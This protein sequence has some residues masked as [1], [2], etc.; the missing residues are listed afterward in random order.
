[1][2]GYTR[3]S[4]PDITNGADVTAP[5]LNAEF[6]QVETAFGTGG[7]SHDGTAGNAPKINLA[8]S[9][10]GFLPSTNGGIGGKNNVTATSNPTITDDTGAGYAVGSVWINTSTDRAFICLSNNS[11]AAVWHEFVAITGANTIVPTATNTVDIGTNA[12]RFKNLLLSGTATIATNAT[13]GGTLGVTGNTT[14][15]GTLGVTGTL[16]A[17]GNATVGGTLGVT[18]N[19]T[20]SNLTVSGTN[21]IA[22]AD[23]N[24][25]AMDATVIGNTTPAAATFTTLT[26]N[27]SLVAATADINGGNIDGTIIGATTAAAGTFTNLTSTGTSTHATVDINGG[28][29]D[30]TTIGAN[31]AAA[32]SFTTVSTSG[33]ATLASADING[34]TIDGTIIGDSTPATITGTTVTGTSLVG[35]LTGNV[36]GNLTGN[37]TGNVAG[38]L[39]GNVTAGS[40]TSIFNNVTVNGTLDVTGTTIANVTDPSSAQDAATKNYVDTEVAA[41]VSSAPGTL[42]T[43]N[44]LAAALNDDPNFSTT[45][46]NSIATKLPLAGGTMSGAIAMGT[47]KITGLG[48]PTANQ[49]AATKKYTT[50]TFLPLAGGTVTGAIDVGNNKITASYTPSTG[51]DLTTKT[52]VDGIVGSSTAA[53]TSATA[54]ANS[55]TASASSATNSANSA[56]AS[57]SSATS[58]AASLATFQNQYHGAQSSAPTQDPDGSSLDLG[59]LYFDTTTNTMK[60]YGSGGW[61]NAGSSVNGTSDRQSYT[62]TAGQTVFAATYDSGYV[63][64]YLNGVKLLA[65]TDF[66]ATNGTSVVLASGAAVNDI[67]DIVA[68]GTFTL[69][70]HYDKT[71]S[72][73]RYLQL[74]GGT[75]TGGLTGTTAT[76]TG[77]LTVDTNTLKVDSSNNRVGVGTTSPATALDVVGNATITVADNSTNLSLVST[78]ADASVGPVLDLYRNSAS[79]ADYDVTGRIIFSAENDADEKTEYTRIITY[80][81]DVSNGSEDAAIQYYL[82]KDGTS[83]QRL[84]HSPTETV[85]NQDSAD[86]DFRVE[87]N[88]NANMLFVDGGNDLIGIGTSSPSMTLDVDGSSGPNDIV[89]FSGPNSGGLTFRNATSNEFI[90]HTATS[91]ALIFG[92]GGNNERARITSSGAFLVGTAGSDPHNASSSSDIG[93]AIRSDGRVHAGATGQNALAVNRIDEGA[94]ITIKKAGAITGSIASFGGLIQFGQGNANLKFSN[95]SDVI[96]PANGSG[97]DNNNAIDLGTSSAAFKSLYLSGT[98]G[99]NSST[100]FTSMDG[101]LMFDN[102]Y[103]SSALGPNKVVL[104]A[105]GNWVGGLGVSSNFLDIYTGGGIRFNKSAS[106]TS[107]SAQMTLDASGNLLVGRTS[108][109]ATGNGHSI[110]GGDSAIFSRD[111]SG[112]TMQIGRNAS[113]G[114][115]VRFLSNG[116][117]MG[118]IGVSS[119]YIWVNSGNVGLAFYPPADSVYPVDSSG[120]NR[121]NATDL[122]TSTV[123][124]DDIYATNGT[125]QT[126]D[127]NEK[128]D[129][130]ELTDAEQRVAVAAKGLLRKFRWKSS[131][132]SKGDKA[133]THFG[134]IAQDLQAAFAAE[135][136]DAS[137]YAMFIST[138]WWETQ[139]EVAAIEAVEAQ[140]AVYNEDGELVTE[141]VEA[142]EAKEAYTRIDTYNSE[143]E[144]PEGATERTR[145]GVRYSELLA[146][147][148]AAI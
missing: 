101:R 128:Q 7:H 21:T 88:G 4:R 93:V 142:V 50:D 136:L 52:Y 35:P 96:T 1:M 114:E 56:T 10:S 19:T 26:A 83:I 108:V 129:I 5:P 6:D 107:Y 138:T 106:Q 51:S 100:A 63:D 143:E 3:Q 133:R 45:I 144:A 64:V 95:A 105:D 131:V 12:N 140:D 9:V 139:T 14:L 122:G 46:T 22:S 62:A 81:P 71:A 104:Q 42:D 28:A 137:D 124:F 135:G 130:E 73:A 20:V 41:L 118:G 49:D 69:A 141:A 57:A 84:E 58:S 102:D 72:D 13:V 74:S 78:D 37:I 91:D 27:T 147:I 39:T 8:T 127:R 109:G 18:G 120:S 40:G 47:N 17:S 59:D 31:S 97:T 65:G 86:V 32:A 99:A 85:F 24:S 53:A 55:A 94:V 125:I 48:D 132:A 61:A 110:R 15:S 82:L 25:G 67:V 92:T 44:E 89:R 75:L 38:N 33:Q 121:D 98:I 103:S 123:R 87:S 146:F 43:L 116:S 66:T 115:L 79:P 148:I 119:S 77:D 70:D 2:A 68:Y 23:I 54:A 90:M 126:S 30:G 134:I 60:V 111:A 36:T 11:S 16:T 113:S 80:M 145:M 29:M 112:E 117:T 76:F 34:G